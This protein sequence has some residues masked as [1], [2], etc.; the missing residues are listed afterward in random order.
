MFLI[1]EIKKMISLPSFLVRVN[2]E[3]GTTRTTNADILSHQCTADGD[4]VN[5]SPFFFIPATHDETSREL[6]AI[7][8]SNVLE[9]VCSCVDW[10]WLTEFNLV[11]LQL[12]FNSIC[13]GLGVCS[14]SGSTNHD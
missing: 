11:P 10:W 3:K 14:R 8:I 6:I 7:F 2:I 1:I 9:Q 5:L 13:H 4:R 12:I